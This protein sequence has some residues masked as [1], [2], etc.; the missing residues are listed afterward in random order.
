MDL[1]T[2]T[3]VLHVSDTHFSPESSAGTEMWTAVVRYVERSRPDLVVH[4][5][6][7]VH[8]DP[9]SD[10]DHEFAA[11]QLR[12][13][14]APWR[15]VP[16]NHDIGDSPPDPY[17]GLISPERLA[18]FRCHFGPDRWSV[19]IGGWH[20]LGLNSMLFDNHLAAEEAAQWGWLEER[21]EQAGGE[22]VALFMHKP[23]CITSLDE[24]LHVN[25][26][27]GLKSRARLRA[28][29]ESGTVKLI[30]TGHLHEHVLLSSGGALLVGAPALGPV[31]AG[32]A[33]WNLGLRCNGVVEYRFRGSSVRV[34]LLREAE[35]GIV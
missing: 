4:T 15:I 11:F 35:L 21:L 30:A 27:I 3:T 22:P 8:D 33:T 19:T 32:P 29:A 17:R 28:L 2:Q 25:K 16:G 6:D 23:P 14:T 20:L 18:R 12:R 31:P 9:D 7:V 10:R 5:G 34:R 24:D 26:S 13:L 1:P